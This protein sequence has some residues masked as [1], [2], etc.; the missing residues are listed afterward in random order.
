MTDEDDFYLLLSL[1]I[2]AFYALAFAY[3]MKLWLF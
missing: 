2:I 3:N 1:I